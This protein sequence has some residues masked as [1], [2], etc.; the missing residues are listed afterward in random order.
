MS[1]FRLKYVWLI[2][3]N[4]LMLFGINPCEQNVS[5]YDFILVKNKFQQWRYL[6]SNNQLATKICKTFVSLAYTHMQIEF[7]VTFDLRGK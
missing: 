2:P 3:K 5:H 6:W 1:S 7:A 4:N